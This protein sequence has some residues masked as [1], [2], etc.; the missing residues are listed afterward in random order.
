M[1]NVTSIPTVTLHDGVEIPQLGFGV[2][3]VPPEDTQ[4]VVEEA[5]DAGYRHIDTAAAYRNEAGVGAAIAASGLARE[6]VFVTT[7]LWNSEQ[8]YDSTLAA[9][10]KSLEPA[11]PRPRRPLPDPL[12]GA[13]RGPLPRHLARLRTDPRGGPARARSASPTSA[14]RT[15]SGSSARPRRCRPSTRS[16]CTRA[17]SRPSCAPGTPSTASPPRPGARSPRARCST[18]RRSSTIA[19]APRAR[20]P[21]QAILRWHLQLGNVVI[22]KSVTPERIRE[23]IDVF[24]FELSEDEMAAIAA[25]RRRRAHRPRPGDLRRA[26]GIL[27]PMAPAGQRGLR[28]PPSSSAARCS[29]SARR[30]RRPTSAG[31]GWRGGLPGRRRLLQ[32]R[33]LRLGAAGRQRPAADAGAWRWWSR[34]P[35]RLE[36]LSAS[37]SSPAPWSS[38]ST[39]STRSSATSARPSTT[40]WSGRRTW[41]AAR[42][43]SSPATWRWSRSPAA[44]CPAGARATSAGGSSPSTSSARSSS[45]SPPSPPSSAADGDMLAVGIANWG[46]LTGALCFAVAGVMQEFER[47]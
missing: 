9:F 40:A 15:S 10:E 20:R 21:A 37:S 16:S 33:R 24:D 41:S 46:T 2:F 43:S 34:E 3:Q 26:V 17:S 47:P 45:W 29:R 8:G 4:E 1:T 13:D 35:R 19:A 36:W 11:R 28:R 7:K 42:S 25:P 23:N 30:W 18:T 38:R 39:W 44:G 6:E 12:A 27:P 32:H 5:L 22:P 14:S 31:R